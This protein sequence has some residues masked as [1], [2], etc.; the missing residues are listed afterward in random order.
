VG[1]PELGAA[2]ALGPEPDVGDVTVTAEQVNETWLRRA[3]LPIILAQSIERTYAILNILSAQGLVH[4]SSPS[5][6]EVDVEFDTNNIP[7]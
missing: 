5:G 4:T 3:D 7:G 6:H 2:R 1:Q